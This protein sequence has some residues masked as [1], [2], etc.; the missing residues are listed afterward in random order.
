VASGHLGTHSLLKQLE[1][2]ANKDLLYHGKSGA[3]RKDTTAVQELLS[4]A[5]RL[6]EFVHYFFHV[7]PN[8]HRL[9]F[10][11]IC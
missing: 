9:L 5:W 10:E 2:A 7:T 1:L 3:T 11:K 8:L 4:G 6:R